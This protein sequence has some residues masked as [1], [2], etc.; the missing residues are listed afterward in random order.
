MWTTVSLITKWCTLRFSFSTVSW[1]GSRNF[2][3]C[4]NSNFYFY[5]PILIS[6]VALTVYV[7]ARNKNRRKF[8]GITDVHIV[9]LFHSRRGLIRL[10][11]CLCDFLSASAKLR[12]VIVT[13][14]AFSV[15]KTFNGTFFWN[16]QQTIAQT[17]F[18][19]AHKC[20]LKRFVDE[21]RN[22]YLII[23][24]LGTCWY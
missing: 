2:R 6:Q 23:D 16:D 5:S 19:I 11:N 24:F 9:S 12:S 1:I 18:E 3:T 13:N 17:L 20:A 10:W 15:S 4:Y 8:F 22:F 14:L 7:N 21:S